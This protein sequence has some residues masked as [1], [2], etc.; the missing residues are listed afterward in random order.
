M[1][2]NTAV[3]RTPYRNVLT[4]LNTFCFIKKA[5]GAAPATIQLH[6]SILLPFLHDNP[7]FFTTQGKARFLLI[8]NRIM[9]GHD[10]PGSR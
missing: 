10:L 3:L 8:Q 7:S 6:R 9:T 2:K 4:A 5:E 1:E